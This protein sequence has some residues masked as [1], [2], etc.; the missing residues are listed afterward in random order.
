[1]LSV[2]G[3]SPLSFGHFTGY[4]VELNTIVTLQNTNLCAFKDGAEDLIE[5]V[6][7]NEKEMKTKIEQLAKHTQK[8]WHKVQH[9]SELLEIKR[10]KYVDMR[11]RERA[12]EE[13]G[14]ES[15]QEME[16]AVQNFNEVIHENEDNIEKLMQMTNDYVRTTADLE[17][18]VFRELMQ[19][20]SRMHEQL[21]N[22]MHSML[23][24]PTSVAPL[25]EIEDTPQEPL[26]SSDRKVLTAQRIIDVTEEMLNAEQNGLIPNEDEVN[27]ISSL[28][29]QFKFIISNTFKKGFFDNFFS[30]KP[31]GHK[32]IEEVLT[33]MVEESV[34]SDAA[35]HKLEPLLSS[36]S[37]RI[38]ITAF[39]PTILPPSRSLLS[40]VPTIEECSVAAA[41]PEAL[42]RF[43]L[44]VLNSASSIRD[45]LWLCFFTLYLQSLGFALPQ[46]LLSHTAYTTDKFWVATLF[47]LASHIP[48]DKSAAVSKAVNDNWAQMECRGVRGADVE[49][50][51]C[52]EIAAGT[53]GTEGRG[54]VCKYERKD[55][56]VV[57]GSGYQE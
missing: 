41:F 8:V 21:V 46:E 36:A 43:S 42:T 16:Q 31:T 55:L 13:V 27:E 20:Y 38:H 26:I 22:T 3:P 39:L 17:K 30:T 12:G 14:R 34:I 47:W 10:K 49:K 5:Q 1:M 2:N 54:N 44:L 15:L 25:I 24:K 29:N 50:V 45:Y 4:G 28:R 37:N 53:P 56:V 40:S 35:L 23:P 52:L 18:S 7:G 57:V 32:V 11:V 6:R 48:G 19:D 33:K 9:L 51:V